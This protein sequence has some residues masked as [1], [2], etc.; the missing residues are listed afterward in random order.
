VQLAPD[1]H[2][3]VAVDGHSR[4]AQI[5]ALPDERDTTCGGFL[6]RAATW[7]AEHGWGAA[8]P[9]RQRQGLPRRHRLAGGLRGSRSAARFINPG[10]GIAV[11]RPEAA[12][13]RPVAA[14]RALHR[15]RA[16]PPR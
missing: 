9:H 3:H 11:R 8:D 5:E 1:D 2:L 15:E 6:H 16:A 7:F 14:E 13:D 12:H 4:L 10:A